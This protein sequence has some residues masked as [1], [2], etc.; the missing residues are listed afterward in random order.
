M[1]SMRKGSPPALHT[2]ILAAGEGKRMRSAR[3]KL[4]H[5]VAGD[6]MVRIVAR[7]AR[8]LKPQTLAVV[9]GTQAE[10]VRAALETFSI[11]FVTQNP[12]LG[13]AHAVMQAEPL[14]R[15]LAGGLKGGRG[16]LLIL[17]GDLPLITAAVLK[18]LLKQHRASG[19]AATVLSTVVAD[20]SGYGRI[21]RG[22]SGG[23][24]RIVEDRDAEA[25]EKRIVEINAGLYCAEMPVLF[26]ALRRTGRG[27]A[28]GEYYL[29]DIF[30]LLAKRGLIVEAYRH[31]VA[32]EVLGVNDRS[33]LAAASRILWRRRADALMASGVSVVDP[34]C[35]YI[36]S[37]VEVGPDTVIW[38]QARIEGR[39]SIGAGC[40][41]GSLA[42]IM[43]S[44]IGDDVT[45]RNM[46]VISDSRVERG[47]RVGPF[48]H[49]RPG[50]VIEE[51]AH[52]GNFVEVKKSRIGRGSKANHLAYVGDATVGADC[53]IG[54]GTITCNYDG[55]RKH[56]T[57]LE[58]GV[59]IGSD[60]Q[61]VAPVRLGRGAYI[62]AGST[63][64]KDVPGGALA[65]TRAELRII[66][67]WAERRRAQ[68]AAEDAGTTGNTVKSAPAATPAGRPK[69]RRGKR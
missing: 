38:P 11:E 57:I 54:A 18:R 34:S 8:E 33:E 67:G 42:H 32:E 3:V 22:A 20:P 61:L 30:P 45:V 24:A 43:D 7:V 39:T 63:I 40:S 25:A 6:P 56:P 5:E 2:L 16:T 14:M 41:I 27:N 9:V 68:Q 46:C 23:L 1:S 58:D 60:T 62:G 55:V 36:G 37:D 65:L 47:A 13:T 66:P 59:F 44:I 35:T 12:P 50:T 49:V 19:A 26:D 51:A 69:T 48:A 10:E 64:T 28:Q 29:P 4:L 31:P 21:V 15:R 53:N 52:I 17:N